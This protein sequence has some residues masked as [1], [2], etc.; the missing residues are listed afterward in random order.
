MVQKMGF[1]EFGGEVET[2]QSQT[3]DFFFSA[4]PLLLLNHVERGIIQ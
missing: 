1:S 4:V 3:F 2:E